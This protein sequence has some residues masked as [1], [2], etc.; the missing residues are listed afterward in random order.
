MDAK[1]VAC[2]GYRAL[3]KSKG[4]VISGFRNRLLAESVR[5]APRKLVTSIS[6]WVSEKVD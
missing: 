1:T 6:R 3:M 4:L 5:F 2:D